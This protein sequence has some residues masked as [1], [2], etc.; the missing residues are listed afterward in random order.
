MKM[1]NPG[2]AFEIKLEDFMHFKHVFMALGPCIRGF[3]S[4]RHHGPDFAPKLFII[5]IASNMKILKFLRQ[6]WES[7]RKPSTPRPAITSL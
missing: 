1:E 2:L 3:T 7:Y 5:S 4:C 6:F